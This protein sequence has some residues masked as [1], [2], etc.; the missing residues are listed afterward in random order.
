MYIGNFE[1]SM[2]MLLLD[3]AKCHSRLYYELVLMEN[4]EKLVSFCDKNK[5]LKLSFGQGAMIQCII[6]HI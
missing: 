2:D 6:F 4:Q 5:Y 3:M 1:S